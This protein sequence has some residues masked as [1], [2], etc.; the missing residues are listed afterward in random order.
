MFWGGPEWSKMVRGT[1]TIIFVPLI[2]HIVNSRS[3]ST[4]FFAFWVSPIVPDF[5]G[6]WAHWAQ[7][8]WAQGPKGPWVQGPKTPPDE[9]WE[10]VWYPST[11]GPR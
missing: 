11:P 9:D 4:Q 6:P 8:A 3:I 10:F 2:P 5:M 7:W 1:R